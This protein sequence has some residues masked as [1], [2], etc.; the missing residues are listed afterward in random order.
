[1]QATAR[2]TRTP[3]NHDPAATTPRQPIRFP[4]THQGIP[5]ASRLVLSRGGSPGAASDP[6]PDSI[7]RVL[8]AM[9][10][11]M[12]AKQLAVARASAGVWGWLA[13]GVIGGRKV[14]R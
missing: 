8:R 9:G 14:A 1:M 5:R 13:R 6:G 12:E 7:E 2:T 11:S 4:S 3:C 10:K